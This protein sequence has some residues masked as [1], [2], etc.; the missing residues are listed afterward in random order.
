M[1][2]IIERYSQIRR[3]EVKTVLVSALAF[4]FILT[5]LMML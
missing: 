5:A 2:T 3:E 1:T 4:F